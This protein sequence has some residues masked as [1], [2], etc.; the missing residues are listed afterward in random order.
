MNK[1][2]YLVFWRASGYEEWAVK[3]PGGGIQ[4][5]TADLDSE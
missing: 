5:K 1:A 4:L 2:V 3:Q